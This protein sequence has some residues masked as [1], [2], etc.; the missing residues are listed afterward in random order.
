MKSILLCTDGS[1]YAEVCCRY[2]AWLSGR[3]GAKLEVIYVSNVWEYD[4]PFV[5]DLGGSMGASPYAGMIANLQEMEKHK[6]KM[7]EDAVGNI[8]EKTAPGLHHDFHHRTGNLVD[9]LGDFEGEEHD[10]DLVMLGKRGENARAA[11]GHLGVT[12]ER[13]VRASK[14]PVMVTNREFRE[15]RKIVFAWDGGQSGTKA[16]NWLTNSNAVEG[17]EFHVV[18]VG[19]GQGEGHA[20]RT[21]LHAEETLNK[22]GR[23]ATCQV[24]TGDVE[25]AIANYVDKVKADLLVMGAYGHSRIR[26]LLIGSTTTDL[27]RRCRIPVLLFR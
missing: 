25:D 11:S 12:M 16:L 21:L 20:S 27:I 4:M 5:M 9:C 23:E 19:E 13:V 18:T 15:I 8:L 24:L 1:A 3:T 2:A 26:H 10:V 22:A 14:K 17:L 7:L 6:A